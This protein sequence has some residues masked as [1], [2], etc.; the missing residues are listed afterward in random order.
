MDILTLYFTH[1]VLWGPGK[2]W[3][4]FEK[5]EIISV[6]F[7][8]MFGERKIWIAVEWVMRLQIVRKMEHWIK[9]RWWSLIQS[10]RQE[11][12][13][14]K[15]L[16]WNIVR[17]RKELSAAHTPMVKK[18]PR[19]A[20][21]IFRQHSNSFLSFLSCSLFCYL[22]RDNLHSRQ[23]FIV[24]RGFCFF[25]HR[26][27][28]FSFLFLFILIWFYSRR[29]CV[30]TPEEEEVFS[31]SFLGHEKE[32]KRV[33][34]AQPVNWAP[35]KV[36]CEERVLHTCTLLLLP[37]EQRISLYSFCVSSVY[38]H[39][40]RYFSCPSFFHCV[41]TDSFLLLLLLLNVY[42]NSAAIGQLCMYN[43]RRDG[44]AYSRSCRMSHS[45]VCIRSAQIDRERGR[46]HLFVCLFVCEQSRRVSLD[47]GALV[48]PK[49]C[50]HVKT[51][52]NFLLL[53]CI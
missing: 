46:S 5:F 8:Y 31:S 25:F 29:V 4:Y 34:K 35:F 49:W 11:R 48:S 15:E 50:T 36:D 41:F 38:T 12:S 33:A 37:Q 19:S 40:S 32:R 28:F 20:D 17:R 13:P 47:D 23:T 16:H 18:E 26:T 44:V 7:V 9:D 53:F 24:E 2:V 43:S 52:P 14:K 39:E 1:D 42:K 21:S 6:D 10:I 51:L 30:C 27:W 22:V 45:C 3:W